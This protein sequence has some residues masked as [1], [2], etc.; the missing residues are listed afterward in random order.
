MTLCEHAHVLERRRHL[1]GAA[2]AGARVRF[3]RRP[4]HVGAVEEDRAR[5]RHG[6]A[7]EAIEEG[8]FAGAVRADQPDDLALVHGQ[9][10]A[11]DGAEFAE[12]L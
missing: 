5:G 11:G 4:R 1:K 9:I 12:H 2:D 10:G 7:G 6:F 8:R 3:R